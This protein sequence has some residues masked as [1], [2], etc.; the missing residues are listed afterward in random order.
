MNI[1]A[2]TERTLRREIA[3]TS[4]TTGAEI[5]VNTTNFNIYRACLLS[6]MATLDEAV[7]ILP[8]ATWWIKADG[9][10]V[11]SG[12]RESVNLKWHGDADLND[13]SVQKM[14]AAYL[15][16][17]ETLLIPESTLLQHLTLYT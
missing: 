16:H 10:D 9:V 13:G 6:Q 4:F 12:L 3:G 14:H 7:R 2:L 17:L 8:E 15:N 5:Q 11:M 1:P